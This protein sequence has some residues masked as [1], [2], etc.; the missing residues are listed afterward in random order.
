MGYTSKNAIATTPERQSVCGSTGN[1][2]D[3][4]RSAACDG[5]T[6]KLLQFV[7]MP[8]GMHSLQVTTEPEAMDTGD[9]NGADRGVYRI[10]YQSIDEE[11]QAGDLTGQIIV[12]SKDPEALGG[13]SDIYRGVWT[14]RFSVDQ[15]TSQARS[16][17]GAVPNRR[18]W[19]Y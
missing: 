4:D 15:Q 6:D 11:T 18:H 19:S 14:H 8:G 12:Q 3:G 17:V 13:Y 16:V 7:Q 9:M 1:G 2:I 10:H 5:Q